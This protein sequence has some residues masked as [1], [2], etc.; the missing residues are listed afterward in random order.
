MS[1]NINVKGNSTWYGN[2]TLNQLNSKRS[3]ISKLF[4]NASVSGSKKKNTAAAIYEKGMTVDAGTYTKGELSYSKCSAEE[5]LEKINEIADDGYCYHIEGD[6][7][8][9]GKTNMSCSVKELETAFGKAKELTK[10]VDNHIVFENNSYYKF[11]D[12]SGKEHTVVSLGG[13]LTPR[14]ETY[15]AETADY[16]NFWNWVSSKNP[17]FMSLDYSPEEVRSR[18]AEAG[19][20]PGFFTI[21]VGGEETTQFLSKGKYSAAIY[22]KAQYD[23]RYYNAFVSGNITRKYYPGTVIKVDGKDY[24]VDENGKIDVPYGADLWDVE[25]PSYY[26]EKRE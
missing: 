15:N 14:S 19:V 25:Y 18:L 1:I 7:F 17:T 13:A 3:L 24:T 4:Q 6:T 21:S 12:D 11:T 22:S 20:E 23:D 9:L 2:T 5:V 26:E 16:V 10:A 8:Y